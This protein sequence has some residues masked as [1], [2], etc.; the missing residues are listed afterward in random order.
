MKDQITRRDAD[1]IFS[2]RCYA[3][4]DYLLHSIE[5]FVSAIWANEKPNWVDAR[6]DVFLTKLAIAMNVSG[7]DTPCKS[8]F[9]GY[10]LFEDRLIRRSLDREDWRVLI[11]EVSSVFPAFNAQIIRARNPEYSQEDSET[12]AY[13]GF[14]AHRL[15]SLWDWG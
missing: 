13:L 14:D 6:A 5:D 10:L 7:F 12:L 8:Q 4:A 15:E 1:S 11:S 3:V 9:G 2:A